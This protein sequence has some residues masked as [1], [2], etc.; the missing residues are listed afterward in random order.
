[1]NK[2]LLLVEDA[3]MYPSVQQIDTFPIYKD[4]NRLLRGVRY[5]HFKSGILSRYKTIWFSDWKKQ[6]SR[7]TDIV[8]MDSIYDYTP[9]QYI[10]KQNPHANIRF[11]FRNRVDERIT[12]SVL[13]R[14]PSELRNEYA[15]ELWSYSKDDCAAYDMV[16]YDQF[17]II[18]EDILNKSLP[19]SLDAYFIGE[20]K[21]RMEQLMKIKKML[22]DLGLITRFEVVVKDPHRTFNE[23]ESRLLVP[24]RP[25]S[26]VLDTILR[27]RCIIDVVGEINY[28]M[29]YRSLEACFLK[30]KLITN[31]AEIVDADFYNPQNIFILGRDDINTIKAFVMSPFNV[32]NAEHV[33]RYSFTYFC[34]RI[35]GLDN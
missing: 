12:H 1:M 28:G 26:E 14:R 19:I 2:H 8:M 7:Y 32:T 5:L 16:H 21:N 3:S 13:H 17:F 4:C 22:D 24:K 30:K 11:C 10:R 15:C 29:T 34:H 31:Y 20:E 25:Y 33:D 27:S 9:L 6:I 35:F 18:P 23:E